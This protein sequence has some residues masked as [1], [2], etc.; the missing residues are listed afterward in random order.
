MV[1][2]F[3]HRPLKAHVVCVRVVWTQY[4]LLVGY[5]S[6]VQNTQST[7][8]LLLCSRS[9]S[10]SRRQTL[11]ERGVLGQQSSSQPG[12]ENGGDDSWRILTLLLLLLDE[13]VEFH[14][15]NGGK[16]SKRRRIRLID[17]L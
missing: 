4:R 3:R 5:R 6:T 12:T 16:Y 8:W 7:P 13:M 11:R 15:S 2:A 1:I 9:Y 17:R 10:Q 14:P